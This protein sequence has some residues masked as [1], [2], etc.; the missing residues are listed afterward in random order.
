MD[1]LLIRL[2]APMQSWGIQSNYTTRDTGYEPSK[3]GVI[4]LLCSALGRSREAALGDL[5]ALRMGVRVD[6]E[7]ALR[8][9]F[10]IAQNVLDTDGKKVRN[11]IVTT[12]YYLS[13]AAFLV[14]LEGDSTLLTQVQAALQNP[15]WAL[16]FGRKAFTPAAP[17]WFKDGLQSDTTIETAFANFGWI[18]AQPKFSP[19]EKVRVVYEAPDGNQ[20]RADVP[21]SFAER[22]FSSRRVITKFITAPQEQSAEVI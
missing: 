5:T 15:V 3:S 19:P 22:T 14:G 8:K 18:I 2:I 10:H 12:R 9:D 4:G 17:V 7:G 1:T 6:R 13:D 21:I 11:N 20:I 16:Y